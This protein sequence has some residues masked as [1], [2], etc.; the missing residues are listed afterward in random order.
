MFDDLGEKIFGS[1]PDLNDLT[2]E[3]LERV[4]AYL[5]KARKYKSRFQGTFQIQ[6]MDEMLIHTGPFIIADYKLVFFVDYDYILD[7]K[8]LTQ[9]RKNMVF[10][11]RSCK[12]PLFPVKISDLEI[13]ITFMSEEHVQRFQR[14][15][16]NIKRDV[17]EF[18]KNVITYNAASIL[19]ATWR[20]RQ[21]R[22]DYIKYRNAVIFIQTA[23]R[24]RKHRLNDK[25]QTKLRQ[26]GKLHPKRS[27]ILQELYDT[28]LNYLITLNTCINVVYKPLLAI[29]DNKNHVEIPTSMIQSI[30]SNMEEIYATHCYFL[31]H[32]RTCLG[33]KQVLKTERYTKLPP[34]L[35]IEQFHYQK[36]GLEPG[37]KVAE[38]IQCFSLQAEVPYILYCVKYD[39]A[40]KIFVK[41]KK[42]PDFLKFL[43]SLQHVKSLKRQDVESLLISPIQRIPRYELLLKDLIKNTW[44]THPDYEFLVEALASIS[45]CAKNINRA[46]S[47]KESEDQIKQLKVKIRSSSMVYLTYLAW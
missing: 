45:K 2:K 24:R 26:I 6:W 8:E 41:C 28:E 17:E 38:S 43:E 4:N 25:F 29:F 12:H 27:M 33:Y 21:S 20:M 31:D 42:N 3:E 32:L 35:D 39:E 37:R 14:T 44:D 36:W 7:L 13:E 1:H 19:Q 5:T 22:R 40:K 34:F 11:L 15:M 16:F 30:F 10:V 46:K 9:T 47:Y 18:R 23:F